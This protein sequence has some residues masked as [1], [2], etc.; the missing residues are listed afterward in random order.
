MTNPTVTRELALGLTPVA[1]DMIR[2]WLRGDHSPENIN[3]LARWM[4]DALRV[5]GV[6]VCRAM[7]EDVIQEKRDD[8]PLSR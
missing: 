4:R 7:I 1:R 5:G 3:R 6:K 2:E 8:L